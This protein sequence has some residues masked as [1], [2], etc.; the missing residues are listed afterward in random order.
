MHPARLLVSFAL[1]AAPLFAQSAAGS[2][3]EGFDPANMDRSVKPCEDFYQFA[4]GAW[5]KNNPVPA[6]RARLSRLSIGPFVAGCLL[7]AGRY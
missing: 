4:N 2:R 6:D 7:P 1:V 5:L 3:K